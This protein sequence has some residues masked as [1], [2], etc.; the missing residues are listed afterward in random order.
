MF[1]GIVCDMGRKD[2]DESSGERSES[3]N[4]VKKGFDWIQEAII[5]TF[6]GHTKSTWIWIIFFVIIC[7]VSVA[8]LV[9]QFHEDTWLFDK[10]VRWFL[11]PIIRLEEWGWIIFLIFMGVQ[12]I[13]IPI[14]SELVLLT[15]GLLW[16]FEF[17]SFI[18]ILGSMVAGVITYYIAVLGGRP[19]ME[20]FLGEENLEVIDNYIKKYGAGA[21][22][23]ARAF[24][25][26]PFDPISYASG[27]LKIRFRIYFFATLIG[28]IVR[29][30]FYAW[31]GSNMY[32]G[33]LEDIINDPA[34]VQAFIDAGSTQFNV[35]L[36]IIVV[37]LGSAYLFYQFLLMPFLKKKHL[38]SKN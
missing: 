32:E 19:M 13:L 24:P 31:L 29:C 34:A 28:S 8:I 18:G 2:S 9:F 1:I 20:R 27:F 23:I 37:V 5:R 15:S 33:S 12:G 10:V 4:I 38:E 35:M 7:I 22:I 30:V 21:I 25:F 17:G 26:M 16:G 14:P 3:E 36:G 6:T 11:E